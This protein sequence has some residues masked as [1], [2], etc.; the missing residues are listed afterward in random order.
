[1]KVLLAILLVLVSLSFPQDVIK[2][3]AAISLTGKL[4][5]E[6]QLL[7]QGY[8]LWKERVNALGGIK[9][10]G[11]HYKVDVVY[12][13]DQSDPVTSARLVERLIVEDGIKFILGPYGSAQ[14]FSSAPIVEK[15][16]AIMVQAGGASSDIYQKGYRNVFGLYTVAPNYGRDLVELATNLDRGAKRI[17]IIYE[18][19]IFSQDAAEGALEHA[20]RKGLNVVLYEG[21]PK[22][23]Q[24]LSS[25]M[26]KLRL[27]KPD[28]VIGSGHFQDAVLMVK[29]LKQFRINPRFLGLTVGPALPA[30]AEALG[31]DAEGIFGP[32]QWSTALNYRDPL[33]GNNREFVKLYRE[34]FGSDPEYHVAGA[35][36][37]GIVFQKAIEKAGSVEVDK[38]RNALRKLKV[39]TLFGVIGF[40]DTGKVVTK[41]MAVIQIQRGRQVT[42]YP[43]EEAKPIYPKPQWR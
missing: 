6:G 15:Y 17:A 41:P 43:F 26:Q 18:K 30:F 22:Q 28:I 25:L 1:M 35:V 37:A 34:R 38:V 29:Q 24:D 10:G 27:L 42:V 5:K 4:A 11:K 13:D 31:E 14:V 8:E 33:F 19:D 40:D 16:G 7:K 36:A 23:V 3:G 39:E 21:Y 12:Y 20:R 9:V 2:F 32:V